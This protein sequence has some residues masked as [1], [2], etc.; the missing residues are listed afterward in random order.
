M[1]RGGAPNGPSERNLQMR[2]A[3]LLGSLLLCAALGS[4]GA[5]VFRFRAVAAGETEIACAYQRP[6]DT[7]SRDTRRFR[8]AVS[9]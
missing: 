7:V 8:V 6:W 2:K 4:L 5:E 1:E 3:W 9:E